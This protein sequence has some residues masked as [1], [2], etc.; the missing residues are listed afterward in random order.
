MA[1]TLKRILFVFFKTCFW[2]SVIGAI[3]YVVLSIIFYFIGSEQF[4][5][6]QKFVI[7]TR[8]VY[9]IPI[10]MLICFFATGFFKA[11]D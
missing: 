2:I 10:S 8:I 4:I 11:D 9:F 7:S 5:S 6:L 1:P 3:S